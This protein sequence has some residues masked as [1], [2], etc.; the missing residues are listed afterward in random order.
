MR[1]VTIPENLEIKGWT[2]ETRRRM[3]CAKFMRC[4]NCGRPLKKVSAKEEMHPTYNDDDMARKC[5]GEKC[6]FC[7]YIGDKKGDND[8]GYKENETGRNEKISQGDSN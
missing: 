8:G 6:S 4:P 1:K 5:M 2:P 3:Q 7:C